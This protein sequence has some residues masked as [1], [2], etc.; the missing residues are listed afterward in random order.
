VSPFLFAINIDAASASRLLRGGRVA[1]AQNHVQSIAD[2][3]RPMQRQI[4]TMLGRLRPIGLNEFGLRE[5]I[6]NMIAFWRRRCPE[7]CYQL[8][9]S[10]GCEGLGEL[11]GKTICR[12]VQE[13]LGNAV[14]HGGP[15]QITVTVDRRDDEVCVEVT[16]DGCGISEPRRP[17]YG[18]VG[19]SERVKAMGGRLS[20]SNQP[21]VGFAMAAMLP[22][23]SRQEGARV[24][25][26]TVES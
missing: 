19:I 23:V 8:D 16:D 15:A 14:R 21:G 12:I 5:A 26:Q 17:G 4:R 3:V 22:C 25:M 11:M 6:E 9:V 20:F 2:A 18:L 13:A 7:I 1:E 10:A 24:P